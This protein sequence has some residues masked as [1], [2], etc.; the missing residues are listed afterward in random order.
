MAAAAAMRCE[1]SPDGNIQWLLV[2]PRLCSINQ[3]AA[4]ECAEPECGR[5]GHRRR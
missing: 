1:Y 4:R 3:D 2:K 5:T